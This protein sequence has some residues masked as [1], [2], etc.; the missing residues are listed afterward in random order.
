[1]QDPNEDSAKRSM[2]VMIELY[3]RK[4]WNDDK[5]VNAIW[6]GCEH[7]NP[8]IVAA[9]CKFFLILDYDMKDESDDDDSSDEDAN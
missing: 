3:K 1:L 9:A 7:G 6:Q 2:N 5:T 8:K 4:V